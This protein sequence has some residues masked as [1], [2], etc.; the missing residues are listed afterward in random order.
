MLVGMAVSS[1]TFSQLLRAIPT[2]L[3][4]AVQHCH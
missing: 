2:L 4:Q 3:M 1:C